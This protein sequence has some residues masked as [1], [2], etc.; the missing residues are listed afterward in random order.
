MVANKSVD[1]MLAAGLGG[2]IVNTASILGIRASFAQTGYCAS[3]VGVIHMTKVLALEWAQKNIRVNALCPGYFLTEMTEG[4][5]KTPASQA[6]ISFSVPGRLGDINELTA[7]FLLLAIDAGAF[8]NG[9]AL[10]VDGA[11]SVGN[12]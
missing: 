8:V 11:M 7:P 1:R 5:I 3:K 6:F 9:V 12:L 10:S 4:Y 2:S